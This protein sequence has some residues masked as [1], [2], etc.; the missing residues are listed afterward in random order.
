[1][2]LNSLS[3]FFIYEPVTTISS[4]AD[5]KAEK[6]SKEQNKNFTCIVKIKLLV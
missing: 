5:E 1:M 6:N 3:V 4:S 2:G